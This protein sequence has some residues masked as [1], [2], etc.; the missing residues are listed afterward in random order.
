MVRPSPRSRD[1]RP[2]DHDIVSEMTKAEQIARD[3]W[4]RVH[5]P[6]YN[7]GAAVSRGGASMARA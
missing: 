7:E 2:G 6:L 3:D 4:R 5:V 1:V